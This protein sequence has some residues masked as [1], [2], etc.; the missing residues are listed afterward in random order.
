MKQWRI[1]QLPAW[2][3]WTGGLLVSVTLTAVADRGLVVPMHRAQVEAD[4][5]RSQL[6][7]A[8]REIVDDTATLSEMRAKLAERQAELRRDPV[9]LSDRQKLN[10]RIADVIELCQRHELEVLQLQPGEFESGDYYETTSLRLEAMAGFDRHVAMLSELHESFPDL[11]VTGLSFSSSPRL[12]EP[13][14]RLVVEMLWFTT[15]RDAEP[16]VAA[17]T[18]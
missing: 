12:T 8:K 15:K 10:R 14:P 4:Q 17:A 18:P 9:H 16:A 1:D 6:K 7:V 13:R 3:V 5:Q 2:L 11:N